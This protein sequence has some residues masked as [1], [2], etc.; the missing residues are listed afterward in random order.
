MKKLALL[1]AVA[2]GLMMTPTAGAQS[3]LGGLGAG[4]I[5]ACADA[6]D[7]GAGQLAPVPQLTAYPG[8]RS[9]RRTKL[10]DRL[11]GREEQRDGSGPL[12]PDADR[13]EPGPAR[14]RMPRPREDAASSAYLNWGLRQVLGASGCGAVCLRLFRG[15]PGLSGCSALWPAT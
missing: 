7:L 2:A 11:R 4:G 6:N 14:R 3:G 13:L 9:V 8:P 15:R 1:A 12:L 5:A 10:E